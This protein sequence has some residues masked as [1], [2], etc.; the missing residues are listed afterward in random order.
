MAS[1]KPV[2]GT[3]LA[4]VMSGCGGLSVTALNKLAVEIDSR[5]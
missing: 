3:T 5:P 2:V 4:V 1:L